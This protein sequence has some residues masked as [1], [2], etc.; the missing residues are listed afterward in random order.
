MFT[1]I[2]VAIIKEETNVKVLQKHGTCLY[3]GS[4]AKNDEPVSLMVEF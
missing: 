4:M 3:T 2:K 1:I